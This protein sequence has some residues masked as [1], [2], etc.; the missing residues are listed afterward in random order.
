MRREAGVRDVPVGMYM[1]IGFGLQKYLYL[2]KAVFVFVYLFSESVQSA[3]IATDSIAGASNIMYLFHVW[4][5]ADIHYLCIK[6]LKYTCMIRHRYNSMIWRLALAL[7]SIQFMLP[8]LSA[9][10]LPERALLF[11]KGDGGS[12]FYRIPA[13]VTAK[14][15]SL[16]AVADKRWDS[17]KDLAGHIDVVC[18]RSTD[19]GRTWTPAVN[20][21]VTDDGGGY[22]DPALVVDNRSGDILCIMTHGNG[23]WESTPD[24]HAYIVVSRS[25]DNGA[26]WSA[27]V[28]ITDQLFTSDPDGKAPIKC[29]TAFATSGRALCMRDGRIMFVLVVRD[30]EKLWTPLQCWACFSDDGGRTWKVADEAADLAGDEAKVEQLRD[31]S[32]LM[33][34]RNP[35]KGARKFS[36]STDRGRTW[37]E[38]EL[39]A[40]I[41]EPACNGDLI[42]YRHGGKDMLLQSVPADSMERKNVTIFGSQD[43]GKT[44][45][46]LY[47]VVPAP[48]WY[49]ALTVLPDGT[50]GCVTEEVASDSGCRLWFTRITPEMLF[51]K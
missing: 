27:P 22:G 10:E 23:L 25:T 49:S 51:G 2:Y 36:R 38:P 31:G 41:I 43:N 28:D 7:L 19:G 14:D 12:K 34:I 9:S 33:S 11:D 8:A 45:Q 44:W 20:V 46:S 32:I 18:R 24:N 47:R 39:N 26:T 35:K 17:P 16:V 5:Y 13:I 15:G 29:V 30:Q 42:R 6:T 48:S 40:D 1:A 3:R 50:V 4:I 21:A 37:S